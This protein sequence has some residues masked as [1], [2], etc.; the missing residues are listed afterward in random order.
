[1]RLRDLEV[2]FLSLAGGLAQRREVDEEAHYHAVT[3]TGTAIFTTIAHVRVVHS[4]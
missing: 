3:P 4:P 2:A 1:M